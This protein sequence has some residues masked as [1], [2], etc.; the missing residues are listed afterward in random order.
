GKFLLFKSRRDNGIEI[1]AKWDLGPSLGLLKPVYLRIDLLNSTSD[2]RYNPQIHNSG[3]INSRS[4]W[5]KGFG[6]SKFTHGLHGKLGFDF[7]F[8]TV[9]ESISGGEFGVSCDYFLDKNLEILYN[10]PSTNYFI[11]LYLQ[12][13]FGQ[14]L[15]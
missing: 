15:Y 5:L 9:R 3:N 6:E 11:C 12:F 2:Q 1:S 14:K 10:N 4:P 8:S 13:N 7:N